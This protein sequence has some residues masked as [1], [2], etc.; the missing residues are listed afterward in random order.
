[1]KPSGALFDCASRPSL[2]LCFVWPIQGS[3][4]RRHREYPCRRASAS[5]GRLRDF[6]GD[7]R[8]RA[9]YRGASD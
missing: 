7:E 3:S 8:E 1:M 9:W 2:S 6:S 5:V 4:H